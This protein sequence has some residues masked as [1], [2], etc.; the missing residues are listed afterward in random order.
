[1]TSLCKKVSFLFLQWAL[2]LR[3]V[4]A[5]QRQETYNG[6]GRLVRSE[7]SPAIVRRTDFTHDP[8]QVLE[9]LPKDLLDLGIATFR[10][11]LKLVEFLQQLDR[12]QL[13]HSGGVSLAM[14]ATKNDTAIARLQLDANE[15]SNDPYQLHS[16]ADDGVLVDIGGNIGDVATAAA[17]LRPKFQ[18]LTLEPVPSTYFIMKLNLHINGIPEIREE[19]FGKPGKAGVLALNKAVTADG[20]DVQVHMNVHSTLDSYTG[21]AD[22]THGFGKWDTSVAQIGSLVLPA[23]LSSHGIE[24]LDFLKI[25][26]E[27]CEFEV[28]PHMTKYFE[29]KSK[30][31]LFAGELHQYMLKDSVR[32]PTNSTVQNMDKMLSMRGCP[33]V[34]S[35]EWHVHC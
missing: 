15:Q 9:Q 33:T 10:S 24:S 17:K 11:K 29:D 6:G 30:V 8:D 5:F 20:R 7:N 13:L 28:I 35:G 4:S 34:S 3:A 2:T 12:P 22:Q 32:R 1:M 26:C 27:G 16:M 23:Y 21:Q 19:D 14:F 18:I 25:D 31:R